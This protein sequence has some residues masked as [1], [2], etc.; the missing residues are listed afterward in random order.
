MDERSSFVGATVAGRYLLEQ[1]IPGGADNTNV[2]AARDTRGS[3]PVVVRLVTVDSLVGWGRAATAAEAV[4]GFQQHLLS[5]AGVQHPV[6]VAP[7]DWGEV[8]IAG[9][10]HLFVVTERLAGTSVRE[11][12]DRGR[13]LTPSQALVIGIDV[14]RALHHLHQLGI[15]HG[16]IRPA[17]VFVG[18]DARARL[19][20]I[21]IKRAAS[22]IAEMTTE[23]GRYA[24]PELASDTTPTAAADVYALALTMLEMLTGDVPFAADSAAVTLANRAGKLLPVSADIGPVAVPMEKAARPD[25]ADRSSALEFGQA[26]AQ[27]AAKL[28]RP[29]PIESLTTE[30]FRDTITRQ[31]EAVPAPQPTAPVAETSAP[32]PTTADVAVTAP[33]AERRRYRVL[34]SIA[35]VV[36]LTVS[37]VLAWQSLSATSYAVPDLVGIPEGEARN[38]VSQFGW[39]VLIRAQRSDD[40]E[41]G[42][43]ISTTPAAGMSLREGD[44]ITL[45]VSEG[46][47]LA[48]LP[49]VI[50]L[51][52]DDAIATLQ[53]AGLTVSESL[54]DD[55]SVPAGSVV[56]W[57]VTEQ[58][59][60]VAGSQV[61]R[62]TEVA[63]V[64]SGG[65]VL[66]AVPNLI[67]LSEADAD[68]QLIA[69]QLNSQRNDDV[70]SSDIPIGLIATQE[71]AAGAQ[72]SRDGIV[73]YALSKGPET[74]ELP[75][76]I[77]LALADA[78]K[79]LNEVGIYVGTTS[80]RTTSKVRTVQQEGKTLKSGDV[81]LKGS[82]VDLVFP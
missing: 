65:P 39:N 1:L 32:P 48:L 40:V 12:L 34:W 35:A 80:G 53:S 2:L 47:T 23:Q 58:P 59:N 41:L 61:L 74:V 64:V 3:V 10:A 78:Q 57:I 6:L 36:A 11:L 7:L 63:I 69:V 8:S 73:A 75:N 79:R 15:A 82:V 38:A 26:L 28:P 44:D 55:D 43:V 68:I 18:T 22:T 4:E 30:S 24:A 13:R 62:G 46:A 5:V 27:L 51:S 45:V 21:G 66:R 56:G 37:G 20:G 42:D 9:T 71:P 49:D 67:G 31:L 25:A 70:F 77:G 33:R 76:V 14:C 19:A 52:R 72:L 54:R 60:L 17:N 16:D 29:E 81:V 50:G